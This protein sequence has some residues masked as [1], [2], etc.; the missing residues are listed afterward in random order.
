MSEGSGKA[1]PARGSC[2]A[3]RNTRQYSARGL[4]HSDVGLSGT[5]SRHHVAVLW[6]LVGVAFQPFHEVTRGVVAGALGFGRVRARAR[7]VPLP[8]EQK[9]QLL[10]S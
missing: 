8:I 4:A 9:G 7:V 10:L 6:P 2:G 3:E 5:A 1:T